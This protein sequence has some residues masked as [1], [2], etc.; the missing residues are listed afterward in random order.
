MCRAIVVRILQSR[1][2]AIGAGNPSEEMI[3]TAILH[4]H[5]DNVLDAGF[6][7]IGKSR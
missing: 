3:E 1:L 5:N 2:P 6:S 7:R 4:G